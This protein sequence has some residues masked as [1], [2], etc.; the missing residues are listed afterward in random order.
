MPET[1]GIPEMMDFSAVF[2]VC[3]A[4]PMRPPYDLPPLPVSTVQGCSVV[5][6]PADID[7]LVRDHITATLHQVLQEG[8]AAMVIDMTATSFCDSAGISVFMS[9]YRRA[10]EADVGLH[11]A[12]ANPR[13]RRVFHLAGIDLVTAIHATLDEAVHA[14][15]TASGRP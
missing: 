3:E 10:R 7:M 5:T 8:P 2:P 14:A 4:F 6:L 13:V 9:A 1:V 11:L 12:I 15:R